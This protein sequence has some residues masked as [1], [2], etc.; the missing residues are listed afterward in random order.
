MS[1]EDIPKCMHYNTLYNRRACENALTMIQLINDW[2][3]DKAEMELII[4]ML[5]EKI[6]NREYIGGDGSENCLH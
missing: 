2:P 1:E 3:F 4:H 6:A 5:Q